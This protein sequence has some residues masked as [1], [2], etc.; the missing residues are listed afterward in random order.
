[1]FPETLLNIRSSTQLTGRQ[2]DG[3]LQAESSLLPVY[4]YQY[5]FRIAQSWELDECDSTFCL[6]YTSVSKSA[7]KRA[8]RRPVF[9]TY[10]RNSQTFIEVLVRCRVHEMKLLNP[11]NI[12]TSFYGPFLILHSQL[13]LSHRRRYLSSS[14]WAVVFC[15]VFCSHL[16]GF[17]NSSSYRTGSSA[18]C[19]TPNLEDQVPL[20]MSPSDRWP[21][22][23]PMQ[24]VPF[25]CASRH[26]RLRWR[27]SGP[28]SQRNSIFHL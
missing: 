18:V 7:W 28:H 22:Y 14:Y 13:R 10:L 8:L 3:A 16:F 19:P 11:V 26:A 2:G 20:F 12:L 15:K 9:L 24:R 25:Y 1:V 23:I 27:C 21:S 17:H 6:F 4:F 5:S